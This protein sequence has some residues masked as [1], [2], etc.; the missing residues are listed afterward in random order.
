MP[1]LSKQLQIHK[2]SDFIFY[3][4]SCIYTSPYIVIRGIEPIPPLSPTSES[5]NNHIPV[6]FTLFW[7]LPLVLC[8]SHFC[9][10]VADVWSVT[11]RT[12]YFKPHLILCTVLHLSNS[13]LSMGWLCLAFILHLWCLS[14]F[15]SHRHCECTNVWESLKSHKKSHQVWF[16]LY[17]VCSSNNIC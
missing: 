15:R 17:I 9:P 8:I 5:T 1:F 14:G 11:L 12:W 6:P 2:L 16:M 4:Y 3:F 13:P 7:P 10:F